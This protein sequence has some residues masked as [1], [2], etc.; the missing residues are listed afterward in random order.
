MLKAEIALS[1]LSYVA[2]WSD[3]HIQFG[4]SR[5]EPYEH[6]LLETLLVTTDGQWFVVVRERLAQKNSL[7]PGT[8]Q[9]VDQERFRQMH[10]DCLM[11]PLDYVM[12][13]VAQSGCRMKLRAGAFGCAPV[14]CRAL[15]DCVS[16]S[17]DFADF[18]A[19]P[20]MPNLE[21]ASRYLGLSSVYSPQHLCVGITMLTERATLYMEPGQARYQYPTPV[22]NVRPS[23]REE[24]GTLEEF[25]GLLCET[26]SARPL[27]A[28]K[29]A[30]EL[31][32][33][34]DSATVATVVSGLYGTVASKG[35]LID[36]SQR[37]TQLERRRKMAHRLQLV[38]EPVEIDAYPPSLDLRPGTRPEYP[39]AELYLEAFDCLWAQARAQGRELLFTGVG[40]DELYPR[41]RDESQGGG[42]PS[43]LVDDAK[44]CAEKLLMPPALE[45]ARAL[46]GM[47]APASP[48]PVSALV[49]GLCQAPHLLR[50][51]LWPVNPL[52]HPRLV[53]FCHSL[54]T[55][56]RHGR[57]M[58]RQYLRSRLG[59]DVFPQN[60][61][62]ET[63][64]NVL[65]GL[66]SRHYESLAGQLSQ[67]ALAD[68]GLVDQR[69]VLAL[70]KEVA[71]TR[72]DAPTAPLV[73]FLWLERFVRQ[74]A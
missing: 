45:A 42:K 37:Q 72:A 57:E 34:M 22:E 62:K 2:T 48:V 15:S 36:G 33:G 39:N 6:A 67:C 43:S 59:E 3:A 8:T 27:S 47:D 51:G 25:E 13:E 18:L 55:K 1:D 4:E 7:P 49:A 53:T 65:P 41:Y 74:L 28:E 9:R 38:D 11:W 70:L 31:S 16:I 69:A 20:L 40:G 21:L 32:G 64:A 46:R 68:F 54:P 60:Y 44:R 17:W 66:I 56:K 71:T 30:I 23:L 35:I 10:R 5:I 12:I 14:Y 19:Y 63:F 29:I 24:D 52:S 26:I 73:A 50:H 58:T 61:V